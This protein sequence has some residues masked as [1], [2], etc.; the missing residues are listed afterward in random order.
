[1]AAPMGAGA[2]DVDDDPPLVVSLD[3]DGDELID[4]E[5]LEIG[6]DPNL[7]D[8]DGDGLGDGSEVRED[9]WGTD[10]LSADSDG[11]G[12]RDGDE[13]FTHGTD[14]N[15]P[16]SRPAAEQELSTINI[17]VR[18]LPTGYAGNNLPGDSEPLPDVDLTVAIPFSEFGMTL[19]TDSLGRASF[20]DL[21]EGEY[22]VILHIPGD[23]ADFVTVYGTA[24]GFEPRQHEGQDTNET[25]VYLGPGEVLNGV[26]YV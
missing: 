1:M 15:D 23:A 12:Y 6:T 9:G 14:P 17:E 25:V 13:I 22:W 21:G 20:P 26:F 5:E 16:E 10:P 19:T 3:S 24:D 11:D 7:F 8:S 2:Q 4:E 18:I